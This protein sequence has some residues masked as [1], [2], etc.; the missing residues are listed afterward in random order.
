MKP[1]DMVMIQTRGDSDLDQ[2]LGIVLGKYEE[3]PQY[4]R[5]LCYDNQF[6]YYF[7]DSLRKIQ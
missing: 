3:D 2:T 5:V 7:N 1:G 4:N 6:R